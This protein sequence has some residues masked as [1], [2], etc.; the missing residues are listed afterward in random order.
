M[1]PERMEGRISQLESRHFF[2]TGDQVRSVD[3]R[4]GWIT[5]SWTHFASVQWENGTVGEVDQFDESLSVEVR[6]VD[7]GAPPPGVTR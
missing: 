4:A 5:E 2:C 6:A 7:R 3:G 1:S